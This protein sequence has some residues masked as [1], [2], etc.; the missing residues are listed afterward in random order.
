MANLQVANTILV[1]LGGQK[2]CAMTGAKKFIADDHSLAFAI[3]AAKDRINKVRITLD[4]S[5]TY[6]V[7]FYAIRG[8][9]FRIVS[10][11]TGVYFDQLQSIFTEATGLYTSLGTMTR[12][13]FGGYC[14]DH[15][16]PLCSE[17]G[18]CPADPMKHTAK[19]SIG[20]AGR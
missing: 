3:P 20:K 16:K 15:N 5:D 19:C 8:T 13:T 9:K 7:Q 18:V 11:S 17:C 6:T 2:F 12:R 14:T 10:E 1:Q 4:F